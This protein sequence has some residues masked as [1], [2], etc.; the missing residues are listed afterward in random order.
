[1]K[2]QSTLYFATVVHCTGDPWQSGAGA[3]QVLTD[4]YLKVTNGLVE[5]V[6]VETDLTPE[7][8]REC[9]QVDYR[10]YIVTP[11]FI[12]GHLHYPQ[13]GVIASYGTQ[14]LEWL[15]KYTFPEE[16]KFSDD[17]YAEASADF[18]IRELLR[19][20][21]TSGFV[22]ATVHKQSVDAIFNAASTV[23]MRLASGKVLMDR[24]CPENLRD[25]A[26]SG[27]E[28]S[29]SLIDS[30]HGKGRLS[31]A[32]TPRFAPTSTEQ[33]LEFS[34]TLFND[35]E[36]VYLQ[37]HVAENK[38][39]VAWVAELFPW[40]RSYLDIYDHYGLL[41]DRAVYGHCIYLDDT[42]LKRMSESGTVA[43]FCPTSNLFLGSGLFDLA[44][45]R[46]RNIKTVLSTD[47]GGGTSFSMLRTANEAYKVTQLAG[48]TVTPL[49]LFYE[50][51]LGG[52]TA[53]S[54]D[55]QV[56]SFAAGK[57]AD[58]VV[59][60]PN[61]T[62]ILSYRIDHAQT[63]EEV[64]FALIILGDDRCTL[65]TYLMG[66]AAYTRGGPDAVDRFGMD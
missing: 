61:A 44:G 34:S 40:S 2:Q 57:E 11:G 10:G 19:N 62:E 26:E 25:T 17:A 56:G 1:L 54:I 59:L 24:N 49:Q 60:D 38:S 65:A 39:E 22:F 15:E 50:L 31:Y 35:N 12:D 6:G 21:T 47:V 28:D 53:L 37:S 30:W 66:K 36:G 14:L 42:D 48:N 9:I 13:T 7:E 3:V 52:A 33:Q 27:Y 46:E 16:A 4:G 29:Q 51:T 63:I 23:N 18:F 5:S 43:A 41:G 45:A 20:G 55:S 8:M 64:L 32:V 58:F